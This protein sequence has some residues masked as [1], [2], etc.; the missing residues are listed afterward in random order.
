MT[1]EILTLAMTLTGA[2]EGERAVLEPLCAAAE[3]EVLGRLRPDCDREEAREPCL[4]AAAWLAAAGLLTGRS[5]G[6]A[7]E[8][9]TIGEVSLSR[10]DPAQSRNTAEC[11]RRQ[12]WRLLRP[13]CRDGDFVF[14][15]VPG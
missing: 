6:S 14:R 7:G 15:G 12:A 13:Y 8:G 5:A 2:S 10:A 9:F 3:R 1:E 4:C 11:L